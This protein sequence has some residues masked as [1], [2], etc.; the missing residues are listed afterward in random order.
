MPLYLPMI[1]FETSSY[2]ALANLEL[3][4]LILQMSA[5]ITSMCSIAPSCGLNL[6]NESWKVKKKKKDK[7]FEAC[8]LFCVYI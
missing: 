1:L 7:A 5:G 3:R 4:I 8:P 2:L 6:F